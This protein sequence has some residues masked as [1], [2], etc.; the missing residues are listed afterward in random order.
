MDDRA[1]LEAAAKAAGISGI[2]SRLDDPMHRDFL[3][4]DSARNPGQKS[5]PWNPL[6]D[7]GDAL[8]LAVKLKFKVTVCNAIVMVESHWPYPDIGETFDDD[9]LVATRRAIVRAAA[10]TGLSERE[11]AG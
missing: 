8:R 4:S 6:T 9:G 2:R 3:I 11:A 7:D 10:Q 1:L 5:G